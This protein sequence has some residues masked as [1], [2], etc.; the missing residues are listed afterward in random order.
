MQQ[1]VRAR[2]PKSFGIFNYLTGAVP[3]QRIYMWQRLF[4]LVLL[5]FTL[6]P[7]PLNPT[8]ILQFN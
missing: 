6:L 7:F 2:H 1:I 3:L 4:E 8:Q 5:P